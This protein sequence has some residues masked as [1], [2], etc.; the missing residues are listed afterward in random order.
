MSEPWRD[1]A[2]NPEERAFL[3]RMATEAVTE[4]GATS[5]R[6][7]SR[8]VS[9]ALAAKVIDLPVLRPEH[10]R[11]AKFVGKW[12]GIGACYLIAGAYWAGR[13]VAWAVRFGV[14]AIQPKEV[15]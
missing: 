13:G 7:R 3:A 12:I 15:G 2:L 9:P 14:A 4:A 8:K 10:E 6:P 5:K 11:I 1:D